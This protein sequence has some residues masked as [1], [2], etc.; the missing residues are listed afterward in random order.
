MTHSISTSRWLLGQVSEPAGARPL[1]L[2]IPPGSEGPE[3]ASGWLNRV[4]DVDVVVAQLPGRGRRLFE[5]PLDDLDKVAE[6]LTAVFVDSVPDNWAVLGHCSGAYLAI[7]LAHQLSGLGLPPVRVFLSSSRPPGPDPERTQSANAIAA[8]ADA[9]LLAD[10]T[11]HQLVPADIDPD[12]GTAVVRAHRAA[13]RAGSAYRW[14]HPALNVPV[15]IW[16]GTADDVV[17]RQHA[18]AWL[19]LAATNFE[20]IEFPGGREFFTLP[21]DT[22]IARVCRAFG[23]GSA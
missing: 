19:T 7:E 5:N 8:M 21:A 13:V 2:V 15:E 4:P 20:V 16:R 14:K 11:A 10:L 12:I 22:A 3:A 23:A 9:E 6:Q 1:F 17:S 18:G